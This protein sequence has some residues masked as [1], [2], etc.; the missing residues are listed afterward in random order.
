[1]CYHSNDNCIINQPFVTDLF[2]TKESYKISIIT[3]MW[4]MIRE[5]QFY[6]TTYKK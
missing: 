1:M 4:Y 2:E 3:V 6:Y 5:E